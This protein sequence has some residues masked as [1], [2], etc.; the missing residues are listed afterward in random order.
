MVKLG[1]IGYPLGHS[2]SAVIQKAGLKSIGL[3]GSY[4]VMET[5]PEDL[6]SRIKYLKSNGY[7]GFNVTIPLKVPM[8]LFLDDIDD[9]ANI[10]GCVNTVKVGE[11]KSFY[12][13]NTDIYGFKRAIP[14]EIDL[15][16]KTASIL[17]TG[18][19]SR[20]AVVGLAE[21]GVKNIDFYT[22]NIINSRQTLEYVRAKF[23]E[24]NFNVYQIQ[25]IRSL[26]DSSIIVNATP[27]G[28]KGFMAD[29]MPLERADLDKLNPNAVIYD[30]V[31]NPVKTVLIQEAQKRGLRTI[32]GL[33]MLIY[34]AERAIQI[35]T[36]K[37]PDVKLMKI[38][39]LEAL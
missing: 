3:D 6:I 28:M 35:W 25:N 13:F 8:S 14:D 10:A 5:P 18:G 4:D 30:I 21:R 38:A 15:T 17:G 1:I 31:Y 27:I 26:A 22:R 34:Q 7:D 16:D 20:A 2:I 32:G 29:Q 11:D 24:I 12:G 9:Y 39:A 23:P 36:G 33:D 37:D 19:A